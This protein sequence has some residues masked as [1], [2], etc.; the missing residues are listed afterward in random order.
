MRQSSFPNIFSINVE[1]WFH[2]RRTEEHYPRAGWSALEAHLPNALARLLE[3]LAATDNRAT[4][5]WLGWCA[6]RYPEWVK[7]V[8]E[9]GHE[10]ACHGYAHQALDRMTPESFRRDVRRARDL[11]ENL[12]GRR[13]VGYRAPA[14]GLEPATVWMLDVLAEERFEYDSSRLVSSLRFHSPAPES[15]L[16][17]RAVTRPP[18][19]LLPLLR[20]R[21]PWRWQAGRGSIVELP[22]SVYRLGP[23][24]LPFAGGLAFRCA[25]YRAVRAAVRSL[26][27]EG[28]AAVCYAHSWELDPNSPAPARPRGEWF[29]HRFRRRSGLRKY[30]RLLSEFRFVPANEALKMMPL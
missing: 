26:N 12:S 28:T 3:R 24:H 9:A 17:G 1:E 13:V 18:Q 15:Q 8:A 16:T 21:L 5:F 6:E 14:L 27:R 11:L 2:M 30:E 20:Q 19:E 7:R 10:V 22:I 29:A 25:P 23:V 4:F